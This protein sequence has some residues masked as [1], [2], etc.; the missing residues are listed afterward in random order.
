VRLYLPQAGLADQAVE[1]V[2]KAVENPLAGK[3]VL[4]VEDDPDIRT[5]TVV[6]LR[7]V[8]LT[9]VDADQA[10]S[11]FRVAQTT[12]KIDLLVTDVVLPGGKNGRVIADKLQQRI[13]GLKVLYMS[14]YTED[15]FAD[16]LK[17]VTD[18]ILLRKPFKKSDLI[19][20][21]NELFLG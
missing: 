18:I 3:T 8:G 15:V 13:P 10:E 4:V 11:A 5:L 6:M 19:A 17:G 14:G 12:P 1:P 20:R 2:S 21:V 9:V 16:Q 7:S